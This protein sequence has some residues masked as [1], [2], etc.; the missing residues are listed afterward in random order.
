MIEGCRVC[1]GATT[2]WGELEVLGKHAVRYERCARCG[3][4]Q[5]E[6]PFWLEEAYASPIA[7]SDLGVVSRNIYLARLVVAVV[8]V[9]FPGRGPYL[10]YGAGYGLLVRLLRDAGRD[11]FWADRFSPN[12][13]A[14]GFEAVAGARYELVTAFELLEH[15]VD[16][17]SEVARLLDMSDSVLCTTTLLPAT[18]PR[19]G[20]WWYYAPETGQHVTIYTLAALRALAG[21]LG[22]HLASDGVGTHLFSRRPVAPWK[23]RLACDHR[24]SYLLYLLRRRRSL[25]AEDYGQVLGR[26]RG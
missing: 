11:F 12:L 9:L 10:D 24:V 3:L 19:P 1:G 15:L 26:D 21:R 6:P 22:V 14:Q 18:S 2:A 16:P 4:V 25:L 23:F 17:V 8:R 20:E 5:T 13:F 7:T